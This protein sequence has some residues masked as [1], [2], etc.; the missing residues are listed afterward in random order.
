MGLQCK[1]TNKKM[2]K[3]NIIILKIT[4][5]LKPLDLL[6]HLESKICKNVKTLTKI[7]L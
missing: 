5:I 4:I 1:Y 7:K 2:S 3:K 6:F